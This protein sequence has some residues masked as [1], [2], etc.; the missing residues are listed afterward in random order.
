MGGLFGGG[1]GGGGGAAQEQLNIQKQQIAKQEENL[2]KQETE[3][4]KRTQ[5]GMQARRG[6][7]LRS[8]LSA[9][10]TD[11]ELGIGNSSKLGGGA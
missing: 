9:E 6:G 1:G 3:L 2:A 4:A 10:R 5:A 8:L 11:S 7:G